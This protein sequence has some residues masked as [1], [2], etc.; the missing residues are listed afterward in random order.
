[1][2]MV[3]FPLPCLITGWY[4]PDGTAERVSLAQGSRC[5]SSL[6]PSASA[7]DFRKRRPVRLRENSS[8]SSARRK[9]RCS[10]NWGNIWPIDRNWLGKVGWDMKQHWV[11]AI[12]FVTELSPYPEI[13]RVFFWS[14]CG[15]RGEWLREWL[16][17]SERREW[18][19]EWV[20]E[21]LREWVREWVRE[22]STMWNAQHRVLHHCKSNSP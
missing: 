17:E 20:R 6:P 15:G 4:I 9:R 21:W 19:T 1:M 3:D 8:R 2:F 7:S 13:R 18:F 14:F 22:W 10:K 16:R 11:V 12:L 5:N